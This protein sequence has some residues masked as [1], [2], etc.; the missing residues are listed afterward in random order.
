MVQPRGV[1]ASTL[2]ARP[3]EQDDKQPYII[4]WQAVLP[5]SLN[6][7]FVL[8]VFHLFVYQQRGCGWC[9]S[10]FLGLIV[11]IYLYYSASILRSECMR[12][13]KTK[14]KNSKTEFLQSVYLPYVII[15]EVLCI[16]SSL[17]AFPRAFR[18]HSTAG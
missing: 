4:C 18:E 13:K 10:V 14:K 6:L 9:F 15:H 2:L 1:A 12:A 11:F 3:N 17:L 16:C 8:A 7:K 5:V